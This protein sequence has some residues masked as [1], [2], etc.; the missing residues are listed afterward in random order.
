MCSTEIRHK[1]IS[2]IR[3]CLYLNLYAFLLL[4]IGGGILSLSF[5]YYS[6]QLLFVQILI[7]IVCFKGA[8]SIF[9]S[10][11]DKKR[12]YS[13][14][15]HR[16][17]SEFREDTFKE[18]MSAPCGR[19]L[20]I[21]VLKDLGETEKYTIL[22]K[23]RLSIFKE[24]RQCFKTRPTKVIIHNKKT[25]NNERGKNKTIQSDNS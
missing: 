6:L 24:I 9:C 3:R 18:Y 19:L 10:W 21:I 14:L 20:V 11:E 12:K 13:V 25:R 1:G 5:F 4:F 15:I 23:Y 2:S 7:A 22:Q 17:T 16:N 8:I